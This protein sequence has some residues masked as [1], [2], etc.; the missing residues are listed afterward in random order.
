M[1]AASTGP[2]TS[3]ASA[4]PG[5]SL[6]WSWETAEVLAVHLLGDLLDLDGAGVEAN[7]EHFAVEGA[8]HHGMEAPSGNIARDD[9]GRML[10][11]WQLCEGKYSGCFVYTRY[12]ARSTTIAR[13]PLARVNGGHPHRLAHALHLPLGPIHRGRVREVA[14]GMIG[15]DDARQ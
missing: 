10:G 15:Y 2:A 6:I 3:A 11:S 14:H 13:P 1:P 5:V 12:A 8:V 7:V 9:A 4:T